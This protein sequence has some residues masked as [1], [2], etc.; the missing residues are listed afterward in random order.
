MLKYKHMQP[1]NPF[2]SSPTDPTATPQVVPANISQ[3]PVDYLNKIATPTNVKKISTRMM[4]GLIAAI[5]I[6]TC[7]AV[8]LIIKT[9]GSPDTSTQL[10]SLQARLESLS[11]ITTSTGPRLTQ[12]R[13]SSINSTLGAT[14]KS[15]QTN[16]KTYMD[17]K[18]VKNKDKLAAAKKSESAF[19]TK[20]SQSLDDAYLTGT[21]DRNYSSEMTYQLTI[22]KSKLQKLKSTANSKSF[23]DFYN[24][25]IQSIDTVYTLLATFQNTQ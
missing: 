25:N 6:A 3:F 8:F 12:N 10:Y 15:M 23:N 13:L 14:I 9:T 19:A 2:Q 24:D 7:L 22:L 18:G 17:T 21:L 16:L 4:I 5:L 1:Q 20:L 11:A